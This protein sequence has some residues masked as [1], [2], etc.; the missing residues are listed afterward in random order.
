M[1]KRDYYIKFATSLAEEWLARWIPFTLMN[2][3]SP[4]W[5]IV[6]GAVFGFAHWFVYKNVLKMTFMIIAGLALNALYVYI[7]PAPWNFV[8][9]IAIHFAAR[10]AGRYIK[11]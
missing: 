3:C 10:I 6:L 11:L 7:I 2:I 1:T 4:S 9:V 5:V 8:A